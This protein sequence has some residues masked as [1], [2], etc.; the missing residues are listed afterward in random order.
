MGRELFSYKITGLADLQVRLKKLADPSLLGEVERAAVTDAAELMEKKIKSAAPEASQY[1]KYVPKGFLKDSID[2]V[3]LKVK[4]HWVAYVG[5]NPHKN[6]PARP[7]RTLTKTGKDRKTP[8]KKSHDARGPWVPLV[9]KWMEFGRAS[10]PARPFI[11]PA[12][13]Q[14]W[15][16][17]LQIISDQIKS[18]VE[19]VTR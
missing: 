4:Q 12:F 10:T 1:Y 15:K 5:P 9:G 3:V 11:R 16:N 17:C 2:F 18:F 13:S 14:S 6:F 8:S 19:S 7:S